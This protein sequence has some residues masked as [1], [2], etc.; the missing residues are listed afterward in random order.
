[1]KLR[2]RMLPLALAT[3]ILIAGMG[4]F[5]TRLW[6]DGEKWA[7]NPWNDTVFQNG[8]LSVGTVTDRNGETL[9]SADG[10]GR[11][12]SPDP[13][14]RISTLHAVGDPLGYIGTG[15]LATFTGELAGYTRFGGLWSEDGRGGT[16]TLSLDA[17][18][19]RTALEALNGHNG[20]VLV[21]NWRTGEILCMVSA[22]GY[23]PENADAE[24]PDGAYLNRCLSGLYP[25]GSIFKIV[26]AAAALE[27]VPGI[28]EHTWDC[29]GSIEI[30]ESTVVCAGVHGEVTL[31]DAFAC[32][33]NCAFAQIAQEVGGETLQRYAAICGLTKPLV[34]D[35]IETAVG[36][37]EAPSTGSVELSWEGIGQHTDLVCP[38]AMLRLCCAVAG[39]GEAVDLTIL[40]GGNPD[41]NKT[42]FLETNTASALAAMMDYAVYST[43]GDENFPGLDLRAKSG[44]AELDGAE[45][46]A[47]FCGYVADPS[48]PLSF[49]VLVENG[50]SGALT[51]GSVANAVLQE[52]ASLM[53]LEGEAIG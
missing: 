24:I 4:I 41:G 46:H 9:T 18:L 42:R 48:T 39:A 25:P 38:V 20:A 26:T 8:I 17:G 27:T 16:V 45:P 52:A 50:G 53:N 21:A 29:D 49:V 33:C 36:S 40:L 7:M 32:S 44:T 51:A 34:L 47:W 13:N 6:H 2:W 30:G 14:T 35:G 10:T 5:F 19:C 23:D 12:W 31:D 1:M 43:Y 3:A 37:V 15:A 22:P 28:Q 11:D